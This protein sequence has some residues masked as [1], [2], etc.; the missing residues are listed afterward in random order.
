M[1]MSKSIKDAMSIVTKA[2]A[3]DPGYRIGWQA[4]I[5]MAFMD[6]ASVHYQDRE[7]AIA[8]ANDAAN[9][10]LLLLCSEHINGGEWSN[11]C[12]GQ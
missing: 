4:N 1:E 10:F 3:D 6:R 11:E 2:I 9:N 5:A 7:K 8:V 12:L